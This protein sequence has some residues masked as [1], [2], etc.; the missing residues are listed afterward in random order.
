LLELLEFNHS[1]WS[2]TSPPSELPTH[3]CSPHPPTMPDAAALFLVPWCAAL[4]PAA[5]GQLAA[6]A[7]VAQR[8][9]AAARAAP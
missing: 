7:L 4:N 2:S 8:A 9:A 5:F 1:R 6:R 3:L